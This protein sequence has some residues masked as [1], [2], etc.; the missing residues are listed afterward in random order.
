MDYIQNL[1]HIANDLRLVIYLTRNDQT[2]NIE[3]K[4]RKIY[5]PIMMLEIVFSINNYFWDET[6]MI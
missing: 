3:Y 6:K 4:R 2:N 1:F 5:H